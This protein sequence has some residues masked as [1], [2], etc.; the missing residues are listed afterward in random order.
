MCEKEKIQ[1][2]QIFRKKKDLEKNLREGQNM[3]TKNVGE[4]EFARVSQRE[5]TCCEKSKHNKQTD[6]F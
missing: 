6:E 2:D 1:R 5:R 4:D 3:E